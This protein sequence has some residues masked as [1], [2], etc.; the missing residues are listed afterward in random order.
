MKVSVGALKGFEL[1]LAFHFAT[2]YSGFE[3][4][5]EYSCW[6]AE[7][8]FGFGISSVSIINDEYGCFKGREFNKDF[9]DKTILRELREE[10]I[11]LK[12]DENS[13]FVLYFQAL[14][15][16]TASSPNLAIAFMKVMIVKELGEVLSD[17]AVESMN[18]F[19][20]RTKKGKPL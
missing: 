6:R 18:L 7:K 17:E 20:T 2:G 11:G 1:E 3:F 9:S 19:K 10:N 5:P 12:W 8:K 16:I 13:N 15:E 4:Y 14:P